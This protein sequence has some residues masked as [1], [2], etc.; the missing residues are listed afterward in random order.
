MVVTIDLHTVVLLLVQQTPAV[1]CNNDVCTYV[2]VCYH[3]LGRLVHIMYCTV[4]NPV[5]FV[6]RVLQ[7]I[8]GIVLVPYVW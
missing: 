5:C 7:Y 4:G 3:M 2:Q 1:F 8:Y 6:C